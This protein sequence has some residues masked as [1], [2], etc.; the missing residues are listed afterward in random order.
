MTGI[1]ELEKRAMCGDTSAI[2]AVVSERRTLDGELKL[3]KRML[4]GYF[5]AM[6]E[7]R[8]KNAKEFID[9]IGKLVDWNPP[10]KEDT[11]AS[12]QE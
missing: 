12:S 9:E 4:G 8:T 7:G 2:I 3:L 6:Y 1:H 10:V 11:D 5:N